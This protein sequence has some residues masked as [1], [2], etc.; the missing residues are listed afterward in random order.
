MFIVCILFWVE[1]KHS[2]KWGGRRRKVGIGDVFQAEGTQSFCASTAAIITEAPGENRAEGP[3]VLQSAGGLAVGTGDS[4]RSSPDFCRRGRGMNGSSYYCLFV[5][6][7]ICDFM[8][9]LILCT[10]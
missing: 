7:Y 9:V 6:G 10:L 4:L 3:N 8:L 1:K 5:V 2:A